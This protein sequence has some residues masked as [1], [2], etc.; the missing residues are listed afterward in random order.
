M[1]NM[2]IRKAERR[3]DKAEQKLRHATRMLGRESNMHPSSALT[4]S[5]R[6]LEHCAKALFIMLSVQE[7]TDHS[8]PVNSD[9]GKQLLNAVHAKLGEGYT[10]E[11]ARLL[12]LTELYGSTYPASEYGIKIS[13]TRIEANDFLNRMEGDQA[14][15]HA[16]EAVEITRAIIDTARE[17]EGMSIRDRESIIDSAFGNK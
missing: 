10:Q 1:E 8:I 6:C 15:N 14:Y 11:A 16:V 17:Q 7:P 4:S 3:L 12:F 2:E 13:Q 9:R 5:Q